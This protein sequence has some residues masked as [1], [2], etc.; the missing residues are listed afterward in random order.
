MDFWR[1][2]VP[3]ATTSNHVRR[4]QNETLE[5]VKLDEQLVDAIQDI[6]RIKFRNKDNFADVKIYIPSRDQVFINLL[7][8]YFEKATIENWLINET[9]PD[10]Y[11]P[12]KELLIQLKTED[13]IS[14]AKIKKEI[15][16]KWGIWKKGVSEDSTKS[17]L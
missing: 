9:Y 8:Q 14:K 17:L 11:E 2:D 7:L 1:N 12:L 15:R 16:V 4:F 6:M 3:K 10:W 13:K 5:M